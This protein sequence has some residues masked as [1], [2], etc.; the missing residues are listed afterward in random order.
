M[1]GRRGPTEIS[2]DYFWRHFEEVRVESADRSGGTPLRFGFAR[3]RGSGR[4]ESV[5]SEIQLPELLVRTLSTHRTQIPFGRLSLL[6]RGAVVTA[7][8]E[9]AAGRSSSDF[10]SE[11]L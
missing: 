2:D 8:S 5:A 9:C 6:R 3:V 11:A 1:G 10:T 7:P 4:R